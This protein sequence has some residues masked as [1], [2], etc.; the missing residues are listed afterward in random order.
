MDIN[1]KNTRKS[2]LRYIWEDTE[3]INDILYLCAFRYFA[4]RRDYEQMLNVLLNYP[5][6][7]PEDISEF[8]LHTLDE[9]ELPEAI[10]EDERGCL[11][12]MK[13]SFA[14]RF[15]IDVGRYEDAEMRALAALSHHRDS[16]AP[17]ASLVLLSCYNNLAYVKMHSALKTHTYDFSRYAKAAADIVAKTRAPIALPESLSYAGVRSF[18]CFV[19]V[20]AE[21]GEFEQFLCEIGLL[22]E[23][24]SQMFPGQYAGYD[25]LCACEIA[26]YRFKKADAKNCAVRAIEKAADANQ[27]ETGARAIF[28]MLRIAVMEG[29]YE[30]AENMFGK[31]SEVTEKPAYIYGRT[32]Y[33]FVSAY[34]FSLLSI[35]ALIPPRFLL[36][37]DIVIADT[38]IPTAEY[39]TN[40]RC[41]LAS[42]KYSDAL[43]ALHLYNTIGDSGRFLLD[44]LTRMIF[45][46]V[47]HYG[48][49]NKKEA[50]AY[51]ES[52][53]E[54]S[55][56]G[57]LIMPFI[58]FGRST[59][60]LVKLALEYPGGAIPRDWL[61]HLDV[62]ASAYAKK[63]AL[64]AAGFRRKYG[65]EDEIRL[66]EREIQLLGD[67]YQGLSRQEIAATRYLS[68]NTIKTELKNLYAKL[69][70]N[71]AVEAVRIANELDLL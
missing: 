9:T 51:F 20:G 1:I 18:A 29:T 6:M 64:I 69:D 8:L 15:L 2:L 34:F 71:S 16:N 56:N 50:L 54:H 35:K 10:E 32:A 22:V 66:S 47:A 17:F 19:G 65:I 36:F 38:N 31:L 37:P 28:Y 60:G 53:Y 3:E 14:P 30:L 12:L 49:G 63:V 43:A 68:I 26:F 42:K 40:I 23:C 58:E 46:A 25:D 33:D 39:M 24:M 48:L 45:Y 70:V 27:Y 59:R 11:S 67:I 61:T 41:L 21:S 4:A 55:Q 13:D 5:L 52:A 62:H 44:E 7:L 57:E